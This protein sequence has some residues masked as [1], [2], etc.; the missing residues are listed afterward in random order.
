MKIPPI[1]LSARRRLGIGLL[2]FYWVLTV[3]AAAEPALPTFWMHPPHPQPEPQDSYTAFRGEFDLAQGGEVEVRLLGA[4]WYNAWI[5]GAYFA[6]GPPRFPAEHPEYE[7]RRLTLPP[8]RQVL[9]VLV[10]YAGVETRIMKSLPPFLSCEVRAG[11][12]MVPVTWRSLPLAGVRSTTRRRS[13]LL[14]WMEWF[15]TRAMPAHWQ[16]PGFEP[17]GWRSVAPC[18]PPIGPMKPATIAPVPTRLLTARPIGSGRL[19]RYFAPDTDDP[20]VAFFLADLECRQ[21][22]PQGVWRRYDLGKVRIA[23]P[24]FL[25]D[26]PPG[27]VVE[28]GSSE[29]LRLGR[30]APW[31]ALSGAPTCF[32]DHYVARGGPQEFF[33]MQAQGARFFE[34]HVYAPADQVRFL[35]EEFLERSYFDNPVG[36]FQCGDALLERIWRTGIETTRSSSEDAVVDSRRERG[37]WSGDLFVGLRILGT[38]FAD[39][40]PARRG[41]VQSALCAQPSG[42]VAA[43]Y[44]GQPDYIPGYAALW[45]GAVLD[46]WEL[47]GDRG[48]LEEL[49]PYAERNLAAM[50]AH[51]G[52]QG[53]TNA[54]GLDHGLGWNFVDWG[55]V[56]NPGPCEIVG[57]LQLLEA[58]RAM[59]RWCGELRHDA[60]PYA[61]AERHLTAAMRSYF[62]AELARG[63]DAWQRIGYQRAVFG[64]RTGVISEPAAPQAIQMIKAYIRN[65]FPANPRATRLSDPYIQGQF[66]TPYFAHFALS[67]LA[68][69]GEMDFVLQQYR[70]CWGWVLKQGLTTWPEV[71]D[72]RW[73]HCHQWSGSP[74]W[75]M[76]RHVLGLHPR[77]DLGTNH[78]LLRVSPGSLKRAA[79]TVAC[80]DGGVV[81]VQWRR[82]TRGR[83]A[84]EVRS[85]RPIWLH[86]DGAPS[87][88]EVSGHQTLNLSK[89]GSTAG[90]ILPP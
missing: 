50:L 26:L 61:Q 22:P 43:L 55:Y 5:N 74:T 73:S 66:F 58:L 82:T 89:A 51:V 1:R 14:G 86:L 54:V 37:Q 15:D 41:I 7:T 16:Q 65:C 32:V 88:L 27:A 85:S 6:D 19:A 10:H 46:Y 35:K 60:R 4:T 18:A 25:L 38:S 62:Q 33:P 76:S 68:R 12:G 57:N 9:A 8:G 83:L 56:P 90:T 17:S 13:P 63:G 11:G 48:L 34:V 81:Q 20:P 67:E 75:V 39:L 47:T 44:P 36:D 77:F 31:S 30:V 64:L 87:P 79:G 40:R 45:V 72:T 23:R 29:E 84:Y 28:F 21:V 49:F 59:V 2:A 80:R 69:R 3:G 53:M 71:F 70:D 42:L 78:F 52:P 24:R